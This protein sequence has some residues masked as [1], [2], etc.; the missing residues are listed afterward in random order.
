MGLG[1]LALAALAPLLFGPPWA[2][3]AISPM[4]EVMSTRLFNG[5]RSIRLGENNRLV[6]FPNK[7]KVDC[8]KADARTM[9]LLVAGQSNAANSAGQKFQSTHGENV[10]NFFDGKCLIAKSP[11]LGSTGEWGEPWT[12]LG[13]KLIDRGVADRVI[14]APVAFGGSALRQWTS[15]E[16]RA[17]LLET[18]ASVRERYDVTSVIWYQG[19]SD[20]IFS[21][22][23]QQYREGLSTLIG[24]IRA[25]GVSAPIYLTGASRCANSDW[26]WSPDNPI[27]RAQRATVNPQARIFMGADADALLTGVDRFDDC[28]L[29][30]TGVDKITDDWASVLAVRR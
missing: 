12:L 26:N 11:L 3:S 29:S 4:D 14:I 13:N 23:E 20:F 19:E 18:I 16:L 10:I 21:T 6:A 2:H 9:V 22:P 25:A 7:M 30:A 8:P 1:A 17:S 5:G 27:S 15:G 24:Q 28:H